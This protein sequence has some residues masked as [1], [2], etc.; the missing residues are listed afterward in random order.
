MMTITMRRMRTLRMM[1]ESAD[2]QGLMDFLAGRI[3][4]HNKH[5]WML[6]SIVGRQ[7]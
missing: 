5:A 7:V 4:I 2:N 6:S 3:D 1:S